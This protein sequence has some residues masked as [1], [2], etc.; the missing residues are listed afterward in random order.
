MRL[1]GEN[2]ADE[3]CGKQGGANCSAAEALQTWYEAREVGDANL[4]VHSD[5]L[6]IFLCLGPDP[7]F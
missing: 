5:R 3:F 2:I 6:T 1:G 4:L 7:G